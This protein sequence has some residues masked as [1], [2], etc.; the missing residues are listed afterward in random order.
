MTTDDI[1]GMGPLVARLSR[2]GQRLRQADRTH[3]WVL[4]TVVVAVVFLMFCLPD[5]LRGGVDDGDGPPRFRLA[6]TELPLAGMLALQA[7]LVLPL[8]WR[9]REPMTAFGVIAA[10]FVLQ[11]SLG[12]ALRADV[13]L[14]IA[15]Y[16]LALHGRLRQLPWACAVMAG[17]M[18]LVAVRVSSVVSVWDALFFLLST[19][20]AAVALGLM[21]RIRRAQLAGLRER[22][23]R[24]EIERDQRSR[25]ATATERTRVAREMHDIVGH[26]LSVIITLADAGAY[27]TDVAPERGKEALR[28]IGDTGRQ[29]LGELRRVLGVLREAGD[30]AAGGPELSPQPGIADVGA[31]CA[32]V[33]AAGLEVVYRTS[34]DVEALDSGVQLT[35]YRIVQEALTNTMKH[36]AD[37]ARVHLAVVVTGAR[38]SI[39]VQDTGSAAPSG[40]PNEEGHGLVGMRERAAL[41][42]GTVSAGPTGGG[43]WAVEAVLDLT[44]RGGDR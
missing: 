3:P 41:Y 40:P 29:A 8:L 37:D 4:D 1:S 23:A 42:G 26:N 44:P 16:S 15:L 36:A 9:R 12:A 35:V 21:V 43:G 39:R 17:A 5:L 14:F 18:A 28:L 25:L 27:A 38:L 20:T 32:T 7:G 24:L 22:A 6:F 30:N 13:A 10:V 2:G 19:A 33:R 34:G 11:W 31:L